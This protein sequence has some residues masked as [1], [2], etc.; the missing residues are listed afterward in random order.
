MLPRDT[1]VVR[2][3]DLNIVLDYDLVLA[4]EPDLDILTL[5][6]DQRLHYDNE[7]MLPHDLDIMLQSDLEIL[8][9]YILELML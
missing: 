7:P 5:T 4:F 3:G 8:L 9:Q 2:Q 1:D 6:L